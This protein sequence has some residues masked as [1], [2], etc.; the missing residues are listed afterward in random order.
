MSGEDFQ[1]AVQQDR[2]DDVDLELLDEVDEDALYDARRDMEW[3]Q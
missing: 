2:H 1:V 3:D